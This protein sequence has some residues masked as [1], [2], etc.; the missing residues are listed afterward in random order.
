MPQLCVKKAIIALYHNT[1]CTSAHKKHAE[2]LGTSILEFPLLQIWGWRSRVPFP[3]LTPLP[4]PLY[5]SLSAT[6]CSSVE[7][8]PI[9]LSR[10]SILTSDT[11]MGIMPVCLSHSASGSKQLAHIKRFRHWRGHQCS[12]YVAI[13]LYIIPMITP[14]KARDVN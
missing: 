12:F 9:F 5:N 11:D 4:T 13:R 7:Y 2:T 3:R 14:S 8:C 6:D 1:I 10:V